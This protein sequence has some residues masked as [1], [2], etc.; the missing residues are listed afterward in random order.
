[1]NVLIN[2]IIQSISK[3]KKAA[4]IRETSLV[5]EIFVFNIENEKNEDILLRMKFIKNK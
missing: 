5:V 3:A 4:L 2:F 1:M